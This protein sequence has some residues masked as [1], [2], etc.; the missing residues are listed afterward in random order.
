MKQFY[1][2][3]I[4]TKDGLVHQGIYFEPKSKGKRAVLW[5]HGLTSNFYSRIPMFED[6]ADLAQETGFGFA[7]FNTRGHDVMTNIKKIDGAKRTSVIGGSAYEDFASSVY[8]LEAGITFL[9]SQGFTEVI[10]VGSSTG[11]NKACYYAGTQNDPRVAGVILVSPVSDVPFES[12]VANYSQNLKKAQALVIEGKGESLM[13]G[14]ADFTLTANRYVSLYVSGS[15]EDLFDYYKDSPA[16]TVYST[17]RVPLYVMFGE[18]DEYADRPVPAILEVFRKYQKSSSYKDLIMQ[19]ANH[20]F[21]G[22][23]KELSLAIF[24]WV[25]SI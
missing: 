22:K 11:A 9:A 6:F 2:A 18:L 20:S 4:T 12:K 19:S 21:D 5:I 10:L 3:D 1:L 8:D 14:I 15:A 13:E 23:Y 17:I 7:V 24:D 25:K 16:F